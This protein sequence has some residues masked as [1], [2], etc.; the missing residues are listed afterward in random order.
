MPGTRTTHIAPS[1]LAADFSR[2]GEQV[3]LTEEAGAQR[4]H[5]D[6]MDGHF[7]PNLSMGP[8]VVKSLRPHTR[9][10]L[11]VHLMVAEPAKFIPAFL[12]AGADSVIFHLEVEPAPRALIDQVRGQGKQ[13]GL[14]I[15]P[16]M[17]VDA[18]APHLPYIDVAI[19][20]TVFPGF[21]GQPFLPESPGRIARLRELIEG[22]NP[23][24]DLEV[25]GG[26]D[27][28]TARA[29]LAAG[30]NVLV[31]GTGIFGYHQGPAAAVRALRELALSV[32]SSP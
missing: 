17:P 8:V 4:I 12:K 19:C 18:L 22:A 11:E 6:V 25:D 1:I 7:V 2:L 9:L 30:A 31:A 20:M 27:L 29:A 10:P 3:R 5:V 28:D 26:I 24:C 13:V 21:G 32:A 14:A 16:D 23:A 15:N